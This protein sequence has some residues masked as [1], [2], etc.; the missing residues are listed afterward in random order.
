MVLENVASEWSP[1]T[2][3]LPQGRSILGPLLFTIFINTLPDSLSPGSQ[4]AL[5][6]DYS[7]V[8][9]PITFL[10]DSM[11]LQQDLNNLKVWSSKNSMQFNPSKCKILTVTKKRNPITF[12]YKLTS[13][14]LVRCDEERDLRMTITY[15]LKLDSR[16]TKIRSTANKCLGLLKRTCYD[17]PDTRVRR[18]LYL[19]LVKSHL[20]Y[21]SQ[22]WSPELLH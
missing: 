3:G 21:G 5:H 19:L 7:K 10:V 20:S 9:R 11:G 17:L 2:S 6:A 12:P 22:V 4:A 13:N 8:Y 15:N 1:V 18:A 16:I 14:D